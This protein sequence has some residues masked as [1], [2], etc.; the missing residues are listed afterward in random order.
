MV[1][2]V[3]LL[4]IKLI[5]IPLTLIKLLKLI[6]TLIKLLKLILPS[7]VLPPFGTSLKEGHY[8]ERIFEKGTRVVESVGWT[9]G[10]L[11]IAP[12]ERPEGP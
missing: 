7:C 11:G 5:N 10:G 12:G 3:V 9:S 6:L 1:V 2:L 4:I 8:G